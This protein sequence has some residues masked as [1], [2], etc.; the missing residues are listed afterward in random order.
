M[1]YID[2]PKLTNRTIGFDSLFNELSSMDYSAP[3]YPPHNIEKDKDGKYVVTVAVA[4][5]PKDSLKVSVKDS[6]AT[7]SGEKEKGDSEFVYKGIGARNFRLFFRL[8]EYTEI[9]S[10]ELVDGILRIVFFQNLPED[11][12][13]KVITIS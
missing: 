11:K 4:G 5:F 8:S 2:I 1:T 10:A 6:I 13:E 9:E 12:K 7:I 3:A